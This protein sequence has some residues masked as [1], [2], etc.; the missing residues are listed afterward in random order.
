[1]YNSSNNNNDDDDDDDKMCEMIVDN[2][3]A[4]DSSATAKTNCQFVDKLRSRCRPAHIPTDT[5]T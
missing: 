4:T 2:L 1:M 3:T 5:R